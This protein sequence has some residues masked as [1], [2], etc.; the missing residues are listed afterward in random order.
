MD[1]SCCIDLLVCRGTDKRIRASFDTAGR[2]SK[3]NLFTFSNPTA[4]SGGVREK[5]L[6]YDVFLIT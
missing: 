2:L 1:N 3:T 5:Y 6:I 4:A